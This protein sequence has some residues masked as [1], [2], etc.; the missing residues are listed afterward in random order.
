MKLVI[1]RVKE[2]SVVIN[3]ELFSRIGKGMVVFVAIGKAD[4]FEDIDYLADKTAH[5]RMFEDEGG[6]MNLS[7]VD[8]KAEFLIVSQFT[9]LSDCAK[10]RR[11]SFDEAADPQKAEEFYG[12]FIQRVRDHNLRVETGKFQAMMEVGL[13]NDGPVTFILDSSSR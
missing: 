8:T 11:P 12:Y 2:A 7:A 5:L 1:Q 13:I 9:L 3:G 4:T 10:G 6:K